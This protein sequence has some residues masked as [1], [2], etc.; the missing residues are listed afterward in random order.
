MEKETGTPPQ[1]Q[2]TPSRGEARGFA[3]VMARLK[4][5]DAA[6]RAALAAETEETVVGYEAYSIGQEHLG[7]GAHAAA[8]RWLKIAARH[9]VPG[10]EQALAELAAHRNPPGFTQFTA[11]D[12]HAV[13]VDVP[14][15]PAARTV[16]DLC[17]VGGEGWERVTDVQAMQEAQAAR[18]EAEQITLQAR[19]QAAEELRQAQERAAEALSRAE[20]LEETMRRQAEETA[21]HLAEADRVRELAH[22]ALAMAELYAGSIY[23]LA[24]LVETQGTLEEALSV[25]ERLREAA[26]RTPE[27]PQQALSKVPFASRDT[28]RV[29]TSPSFI[30]GTGEA[31]DGSRLPDDAQVVGMKDTLVVYHTVSPTGERQD[32]RLRE[33]DSGALATALRCGDMAEPVSLRDV[34]L[35]PGRIVAARVSEDGS[36]EDGEG[37]L[38]P[39]ISVWQVGRA[40]LTVTSMI[41]PWCPADEASAAFRAGADRLQLMAASSLV[42][43]SEHGQEQ[44]LGEP[45]ARAFDESRRDPEEAGTSAG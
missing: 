5:S 31:S 37:A 26:G 45:D 14:S 25:C 44:N 38:I 36:G 10:A 7:R 28:A 6:E 15:F 1:D 41:V 9:G 34:R 8:G 27:E 40:P 19:R 22:R 11:G 24:R 17:Q 43:L 33:P 23:A 13:V 39:K 35:W 12:G 2:H 32:A 21:R 30:G 3:S 20:E 42:H 29:L 16:L 4:G 18:A